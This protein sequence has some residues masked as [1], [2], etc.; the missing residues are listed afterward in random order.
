MRVYIAGHDQEH[1]RSEF[2]RAA[3]MLASYGAD[4]SSPFHPDLADTPGAWTQ[5]RIEHVLG[6]DAVVVLPSHGM[7][8]M[9]ELLARTAGIPVR[10]LEE[11]LASVGRLAVA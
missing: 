8:S 7:T 3:R 4:V 5:N 10:T 2:E 1:A 9:D 6:A 11:V